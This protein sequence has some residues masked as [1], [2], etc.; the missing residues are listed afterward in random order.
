MFRILISD[1]LGEAGLERLR[2]MDDVQHDVKLGLEKE[3]L[4]ATIPGYDALII[5]SG[6]KVDADVLEA[7][8]KLKVIGRAGIGVDN[9]DIRAATREGVIVM[10]TPAANSIATAEQTMALMLAASRHTAVA[11]Q[12][13]KEGEW[14]RTQ[15]VGSELNGK[16]LG[17]IGFGRI[18]RLV[19][20]RA[21]AF[22]MTIMAY[23]PLVTEDVAREMDVTLVDMDDLLP[24][25]DYITLHAALVPDTE[26]IINRSAVE[27]MKEGVIFINV[28]RGKMVDEGALAAGLEQ[29]KIK[30]AA[31]DVYRSEPPST[32]NPLIGHPRVLH[33]PHLGASTVEAQHAVAT[34]IVEQVVNAL[35]GSDFRNSVNMPFPAGP[36]FATIRPYMELAEKLG[37][38]HAG[39]AEGP[40]IR[41]EIEVHGEDVTG[42]VRAIA[43]ALLKGIL[44]HTI[45]ESINYVNAPILAD[46]HGISISQTRG[47]N[48][49]DY[50]NL[51]SCRVQWAGGENML[52]GMLFG[53]R[54]PRVVRVNKYAV[55]ARPVGTLLLMQNED[56]PGVIGQIGTILAAY[57]INI[58]E[59][60]MGRDRPGGEALSVI[61]LDSVPPQPVLDALERIAA[62]TKLN[63]VHLQT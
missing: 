53:G 63:L 27:Q 1:K 29:G 23:D 33:T 25:A 12:S 11:H 18:G 20:K 32:D 58:G 3:S 35:R 31:I 48:P 37:N 9:V 26:N 44:S 51:V 47:K 8:T 7:A 14:K 15:F 28:A 56:V 21:Q 5:R 24:Q 62:I 46:Q 45:G 57:D 17:I 40:I 60:R 10:N 50:P 54:E 61:S 30:L 4:L 55:D 16:V 43:A 19:A 52:A 59:W 39:L 41:V 6:T 42:L 22:G 13:V 34:Q 36:D 49:I 38:L 2:Q